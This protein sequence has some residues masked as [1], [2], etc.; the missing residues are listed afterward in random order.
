MLEQIQRE[1]SVCARTLRLERDQTMK[2]L[3]APWQFSDVYKRISI[4]N[5]HRNKQSQTFVGQLKLIFSL[6]LPITKRTRRER[7]KV[8]AISK[9]EKA[10]I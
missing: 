3:S 1:A 9:A 6:Q 8:G 10:Q 2:S 4:R 5:R 7:P